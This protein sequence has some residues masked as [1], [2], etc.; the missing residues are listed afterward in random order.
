[1][2]CRLCMFWNN[3]V[4]QGLGCWH[5]CFPLRCCP[6]LYLCVLCF[7]SRDVG[8]CEGLIKRRIA[9]WRPAGFSC[10]A[11][12]RTQKWSVSWSS[13]SRLLLLRMGGVVWP[14]EPG[15]V[16]RAHEAGF[17]EHPALMS[18]WHPYTLLKR[19]KTLWKR[20]PFV[21]RC[22]FIT[23][24]RCDENKKHQPSPVRAV[25][26]GAAVLTSSAWVSLFSRTLQSVFIFLK[27]WLVQ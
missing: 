22:I 12:C 11:C 2:T 9:G 21:I 14:W 17:P 18:C 19:K 27:L 25:K 24:V 13:V 5:A 26:Q 16:Q 4:C 10:P 3:N 15:C 20:V 7:L 1:M 23:R 6:V 8:S